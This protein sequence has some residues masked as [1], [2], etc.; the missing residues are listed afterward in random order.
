LFS[1]LSNQ[2]LAIGHENESVQILKYGNLSIPSLKAFQKHN[3]WVIHSYEVLIYQNKTITQK[4]SRMRYVIKCFLFLTI[5]ILALSCNRKQNIS[6]ISN[7]NL[8]GD[9][10]TFPYSINDVLF[11]VPSPHQI[12]LLI[13]EDCPY[14]DEKTFK[15][16][17]NIR[18]Y[19]TSE[20]RALVIGALGADLGYLSLYDQKGL[21][22]KYLEDIRYLAEEL[23]LTPENSKSQFKMLSENMDNC[24]SMLFMISEIYR[25]GNQ[26]LKQGDRQYLSNLIIAGGW[27]E[28]FYLLNNLYEDSKNSNLFGIILQ[29]QYVIDNLIKS[30]QPFYNKS[31][32]FTDLIDKL[33]EIAYEYEVVDMHYKNAP[34]ENTDKNNLTIVKCRFTPVLTGSHLEKILDLSRALRKKLIF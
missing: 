11:S 34:P 14:F 24:D 22:L 3:L 15:N 18:M 26:Y 6:E 23:K 2:K 32:E 8:S 13:K 10:A 25:E 30:L 27:I 9:T 7:I 31:Q 19:L 29:Q 16:D 12:S 33:V 28:S 17:V 21:T 5:C 20:K 4:E 1:L